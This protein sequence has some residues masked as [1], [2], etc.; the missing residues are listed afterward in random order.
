VLEDFVRFVEPTAECHMS[1]VPA[2]QDGFVVRQDSPNTISANRSG[3]RFLNDDA[4]LSGTIKDVRVINI[5]RC[6]LGSDHRE[7]V[8]H[9]GSPPEV[10]LAV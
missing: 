6:P 1:A 8:G 5:Y 3:P 7:A 4:G 2:R 9:E 10:E